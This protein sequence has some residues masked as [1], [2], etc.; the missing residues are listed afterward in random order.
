MSSL[1]LEAVLAIASSVSETR[2]D[3]VVGFNLVRW[4]LGLGSGKGKG[5]VVMPPFIRLDFGSW[6]I[7]NVYGYSSAPLQG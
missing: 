5:C 7:S 2:P 3:S 4:L 6:G 1:P